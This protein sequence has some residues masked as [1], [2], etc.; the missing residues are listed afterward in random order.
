MNLGHAKP[1]ALGG[2]SGTR[3]LRRAIT[4][5]ALATVIGGCLLKPVPSLHALEIVLP[6]ATPAQAPYWKSSGQELEAQHQECIRRQQTRQRASEQALIRQIQA[7]SAIRRADFKQ[8]TAVSATASSQPL[9]SAPENTLA[10]PLVLIAAALAGAAWFIH[11]AV[12]R[13]SK[14]P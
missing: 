13:K 5:F 2:K 3:N 9:R 7:Q 1:M 8:A 11:R 4:Q 14:A 10:F 6:D 12:A